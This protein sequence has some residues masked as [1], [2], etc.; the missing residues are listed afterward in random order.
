MAASY[1]WKNMAY[2]VNPL[3]VKAK[4]AGDILPHN[5]LDRWECPEAAPHTACYINPATHFSPCLIL[6]GEKGLKS[7]PKKHPHV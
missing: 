3:L 7:C 2:I 1:T 6:P 4:Y 5:V